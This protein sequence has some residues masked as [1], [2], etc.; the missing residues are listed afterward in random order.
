VIIMRVAICDDNPII[1]NELAMM[2][3]DYS[4]I[5][6]IRID[7]EKF[8]SYNQIGQQIDKFD[9]FLLDYCM[10]DSGVKSGEMNGMEFARIIRQ[11]FAGTKSIIFVTAH[12]EIVYEAFEV[13][14]Y[15]FITKPIAR[16]K[17]FAAFDDYIATVTDHETILV[18]ANDEAHVINLNDINYL[19]VSRKDTYI[20]FKDKCLKCHRTI[21]SFETELE[22]YGFVRVHRSF[23][24]NIRKIVSFDTHTAMLE[25]G[26]KLF[27]SPKKYTELCNA[28][29]KSNKT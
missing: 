22:P 7:Y 25:S 11:K 21:S 29:S 17:I 23:I 28:Y 5:K 10:D 15:R 14:A 18:K 1:L 2:I 6:K 20:Y 3:D 26:E 13:R 9:L 8:S 27:V 19:E 16:E 24:V 4:E 12:T